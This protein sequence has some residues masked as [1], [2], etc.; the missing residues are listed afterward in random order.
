M[1]VRLLVLPA[2]SSA[3][4]E[5]RMLFFS[6][7]LGRKAGNSLRFTHSHLRFTVHIWKLDAKQCSAMRSCQITR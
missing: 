3:G 4:S 6:V 2:F 5:G 1:I 7:L